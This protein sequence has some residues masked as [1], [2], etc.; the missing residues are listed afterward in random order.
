MPAN[1]HGKD[2]GNRKLPYSN[3]HGSDWRQEWLRRLVD[4]ILPTR[5]ENIAVVSENLMTRETVR[6]RWK[7]MV[8]VSKAGIVPL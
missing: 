8:T 1:D 4:G 6:H 5:D 3:H 7:V 2:Y